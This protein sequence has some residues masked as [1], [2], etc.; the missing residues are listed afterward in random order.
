[1]DKL[2]CVFGTGFIV[3]VIKMKVWLEQVAEAVKGEEGFF[4]ILG[5]CS[6]VLLAVSL[7]LMAGR[8][9]KVRS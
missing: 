7:I 8:T 6:L 9:R 5:I 4:L 1:M 3:F 2:L